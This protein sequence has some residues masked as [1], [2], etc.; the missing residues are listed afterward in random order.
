MPGYTITHRK[1]HT[2]TAQPG[3]LEKGIDILFS[4]SAAT[5]PIGLSQLCR[6]TGLPKSTAHRILAVLCSRSLA[7]RVGTDYQAGDLLARLGDVRGRIPGTRRAVLPYLLYLY[8][9]TRQTVNLA[10][11]SGLEAEYVER[12]YGHNRVSSPSDGVDRAP[13][14]CTALGKTMLAF[15]PSLRQALADRGSPARLTRRTITSLTGLDRELARVRHYGVAYSQEEFAEGVACVAAPVF[16]PGGRLVMAVSVAGPAQALP[17]ARLGISVRGAAQ[18]I[19]SA[20][21]RAA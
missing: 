10:V 6:I 5:Q 1:H 15:D 11:P 18:A 14:H 19:S 7:K 2:H 16:G 21:L 20:L 12:V 9:T 4:L 17:L 8:E 3:S 13:M